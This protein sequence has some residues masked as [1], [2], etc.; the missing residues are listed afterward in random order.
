MKKYTNIFLILFVFAFYS[1]AK[2]Q[3]TQEVVQNEPTA[4]ENIAYKWAKMALLA[5]AN[6]TEKFKPRP[7]IT[8]R[9]LGLSFIAIFDAWSR[10]DNKAIPVYLNKVDRQAP[11]DRTLNNKE[12]AVSYAAYRALSKYFYSDKKLFY[13]FMIELGLDPDNFSLDPNTP[14]GIGNLAATA[15]FEAR[16][17]DGSNQDGEEVGSNGKAYFDY[18]K[19]TAINSADDNTDINHWQP[20]YF[21]DGKGGQYLP[22]CL[23]PFWGKVKPVSLKSASQFRP[24]PP[25]LVGSEKLK[26]EVEEVIKLQENLTNEQKALVEF[27]RDGP[28][29]VQQAGHWLTLAQEVSVRDNHTLDE[30][31]KMYFLCEIT[32]MDCFIACWDSKLFYDYARPY[33]LVHHYYKDITIKRGADQEKELLR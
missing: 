20:K 1:I 33:A 7:T 3:N 27:M 18:I 23:T 24:I 5:T 26:K 22:E 4:K 19:Y 31:V 17:N 8:S 10:Y 28:M 30:D 12:I 2:A 14:E 6:D 25:P 21:S 9:Y 13:D 32:A 11:V 15:V 16:K 29:S